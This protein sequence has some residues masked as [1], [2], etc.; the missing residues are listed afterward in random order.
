MIVMS[1]ITCF[2]MK[3]ED[4]KY[5]CSL[6]DT[7]RPVKAVRFS[8]DG[9]KLVSGSDDT[10]LRYWDMSTE[11]CLSIFKG[12]EVCMYGRGERGGLKHTYVF[13]SFCRIMFVVS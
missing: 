11:T 10:A 2:L 3:N 8:L 13:L 4:L 6:N 9:L 5:F 1:L 7:F 12:H